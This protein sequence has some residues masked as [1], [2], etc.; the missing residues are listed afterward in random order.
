[1]LVFCCSICFHIREAEMRQG[2]KKIVFKRLLI[3]LVSVFKCICI[4]I[5][6]TICVPKKPNIDN[7]IRRGE[8]SY[9][10]LLHFRSNART[11]S[12]NPVGKMGLGG[13]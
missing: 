7:L 9:Q 5:S 12:L 13:N 8:Q 2:G 10:G 4:L 11:C 1:M 3:F 6:M